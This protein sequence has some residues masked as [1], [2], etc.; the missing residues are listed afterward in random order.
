MKGA[1]ML[2]AFSASTGGNVLSLLGMLL[3]VIAVLALAYWCTRWI[4]QR[5]MPG[6]ARG[7][8]GGEK[9]QLLWQVSLGKG[10]RLVLVRVHERC[11]LLGVTGG[12]ISVLTELTEQEAAGWLQKTGDPPQASSFLE[13]LRENLPKRK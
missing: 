4:G 12:G 1:A 13:I 9:L 2:R 3:T 8:A 6:W 11:L 10:E 5:G 7:A